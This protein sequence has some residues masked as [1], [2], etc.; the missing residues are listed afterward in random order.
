ML[1]ELRPAAEYYWEIEGAPGDDSGPFVFFESLVGTY[2]AI[3]LAM[4]DSEKRNALLRRAFNLAETMLLNGD[5]QV[6]DL[7]FI[8][9]LESRGAWWWSRAQL[10]MGPAAHGALDTHEPWWR[11]ETVGSEA[12]DAEFI[13]L[14]GVRSVIASELVAEGVSLEDVPGATHKRQDS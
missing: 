8:G 1:P 12:D 14:Y 11:E 7:A 3:L 10:F 13:D 6:Q 2:V 5:D 4:S 9:L